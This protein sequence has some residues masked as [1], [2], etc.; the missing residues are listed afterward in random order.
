[1]AACRAG[2]AAKAEPLYKFLNDLAGSPK[3]VMPVPCF[4]VCVACNVRVV[5]SSRVSIANR[6]WL[7]QAL[8]LCMPLQLC[9]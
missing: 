3:M 7:V 4:N 9:A 8:V 1:M 6:L 5:G 2:A